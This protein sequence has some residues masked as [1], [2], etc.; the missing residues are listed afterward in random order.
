MT[1]PV[2]PK[3]LRLDPEGRIDQTLT[4]E[5]CG[6]DLRGLVLTQDCPECGLCV[7]LATDRE[8]L[9]FA[10]HAWLARLFYGLRAALIGLAAA[11][12]GAAAWF[13]VVRLFPTPIG[14]ALGDRGSGLLYGPSPCPRA[15]G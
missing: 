5:A 7:A 2:G 10:S 3:H 8:R 4:C 1:R 11:G 12:A 15:C 13:G 6:Y 9:I 14:R